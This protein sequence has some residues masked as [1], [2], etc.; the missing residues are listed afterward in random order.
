MQARSVACSVGGLT[1]WRSNQNVDLSGFFF[2]CLRGAGGHSVP[3]GR[4]RW[5]NHLYKIQTKSVCVCFF[6]FLKTIL[7][8][9]KVYQPVVGVSVIKAFASVDPFIFIHSQ[10]CVFAFYYFSCLSIFFGLFPSPFGET[11]LF[12]EHFSNVWNNHWICS[13]T[14]CCSS[15]GNRLILESILRSMWT[16][17]L[18]LLLVFQPCFR[19]L[20]SPPQ[21]RF[22]WLAL[23]GS[24]RSET[25]FLCL[26]GYRATA[27]SRVCI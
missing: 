17:F 1:H 13:H 12:S 5:R 20:F 22:A 23:C 18:F 25:L 19:F 16:P 14:F 11:P 9:R 27:F 26:V 2:V 15:C 7:Y 3:E 21:A 10:R 8:F 4:S 6:F 24:L